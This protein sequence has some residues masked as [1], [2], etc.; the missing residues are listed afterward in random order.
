MNI[1]LSPTS[2]FPNL[3]DSVNKKIGG[4]N[5]VFLVILTVIII[6]YYVLFSSLGASDTNITAEIISSSSGMSIV[7][8]FM[9]GLFIFLKISL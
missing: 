6:L 3:Y 5:P 8:I 1:D 9:W 2:G 7:E 4:S